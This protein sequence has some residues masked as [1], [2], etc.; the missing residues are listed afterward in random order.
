MENSMVKK[1]DSAAGYAPLA[2]MSVL[3]FGPGFS[4]AYCAKLL[5]DFGAEVIKIESPEGD[6]ARGRGPFP[7]KKP[8]PEKSGLFIYLNTN[9]YGITLDCQTSEGREIFKNLVEKTDILVQTFPPARLSE[10]G[11]TYEILAKEN[12]RLIMVSLTPFGQTGPWRD[13][14]A[15]TLNVCQASGAS[16][17]IQTGDLERE[18]IKNAGLSDDF[19]CGQNAA[20]AAL[21]AVLSREK[22]GRGAHLDISMQ[23]ALMSLGRVD[24]LRFANEGGVMRRDLRGVVVGGIMETADGHINLVAIQENQWQGLVKLMGNPEWT[25]DEICRDE[26]SRAWYAD[27]INTKIQAWAKPQK[28]EEVYHRGQALGVPITPIYDSRDVDDSPQTAA[29]EFLMEVEHPEIGKL[30]I[31][32]ASY[33]FSEIPWR[34]R[35]PA[36]RL[37]EHNRLVFVERLGLSPEEVEEDGKVNSSKQ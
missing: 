26:M 31:P 17:I 29:R 9:K 32:Q 35:R 18:P 23:E 14:R 11:L 21:G 25:R 36:P 4:G 15:R 13:Y 28:K 37:G 34:F 22:T 1:N 10:L 30:K 5:A 6:P 8:H 7:E 12:P 27:D 19:D 16:S 3:E 20:V 24:L 33:R 2:G